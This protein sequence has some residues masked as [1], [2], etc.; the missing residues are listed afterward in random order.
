MFNQNKSFLGGH[1]HK[2]SNLR[3]NVS[4]GSYSQ[5]INNG[6]KVRSVIPRRQSFDLQGV[7]EYAPVQHIWKKNNTVLRS[8]N[9]RINNFDIYSDRGSN[10]KRNVVSA[11]FKTRTGRK[12]PRAIK[13]KDN[14]SVKLNSRV[15]KTE[16]PIVIEKDENG[17][18][19]E[20]NHTDSQLNTS[21]YVD[22]TNLID[23]KNN[24]EQEDDQ[25][26]CNSLPDR[27]CD[28]DIFAPIYVGAFNDQKRKLVFSELKLETAFSSSFW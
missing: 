14:N 3:D 12:V 6:S 22:L 5:W 10:N 27:E 23:L 8:I 28:N 15:N 7:E 1:Q 2:F 26:S 19:K 20:N 11:R 18:I 21:Q 24:Q 17:L 13:V 25:S 4:G 9:R 16:A